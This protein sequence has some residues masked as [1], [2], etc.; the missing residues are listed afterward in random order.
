MKQA[1]S[2]KSKA[3]GLRRPMLLSPHTGGAS[4]GAGNSRNAPRGQHTTKQ[5]THSPRRC[6]SPGC[7]YGCMCA[8]P[9]PSSVG[10]NRY[11]E[12][13]PQAS[14]QSL[15][16]VGLIAYGISHEHQV[17]CSPDLTDRTLSCGMSCH[18]SAWSASGLA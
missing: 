7:V 2:R 17:S 4:G 15:G 1:N 18:R 6:S 9:C 11:Q 16:L 5:A 8:D 10:L 14:S 13:G 3:E 12:T